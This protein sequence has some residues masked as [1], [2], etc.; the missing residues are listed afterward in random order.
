[1]GEASIGRY[2][3]EE[4]VSRG[5]MGEVWRARDQALGRPVAIKLLFNELGDSANTVDGERFLREARAAARLTHPNIVATYDVGYWDE[6]PY[7]VMEFLD[8]PSVA[9]DLHE[10]HWL[11]VPEIRRIGAQTASALACAHAAGVIHRDIKPGNLVKAGDGTIKLVDFGLAWLVNETGHRLTPDGTAMGT[12]H[13]LAPEIAAGKPIDPRSDLYSLGCVLYELAC[14]RPPFEGP[15]PEM[16]LAHLNNEP[17]PPSYLRP[18]L[19]WDLEALI[20]QL[21]AKQ[22]DH[23]PAGA[24]EVGHRLRGLT[25]TIHLPPP[26]IPGTE[27]TPTSPTIPASPDTPGSEPSSGASEIRPARRRAVLAAA[28][29]LAG[30]AL[31]ATAWWTLPDDGQQQA[32]QSERSTPPIQAT[33]AP[34]DLPSPRPSTSDPRDTGNERSQARVPPSPTHPANDDQNTKQTNTTAD[35]TDGGKTKRDTKGSAKKAGRK[36]GTGKDNAKDS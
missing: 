26:A 11:P 27:P 6:R 18:E 33:T 15:M 19:P 3:L 8:G 36:A 12:T 1:M 5:G 29:G 35:R 17:E 25:G 24:G 32:G 21:L 14:G 9:S 28:G 7:L 34:P 30:A 23:R 13:Y 20:L 31:L 16:I 4:L 2:V 22:P 10:R